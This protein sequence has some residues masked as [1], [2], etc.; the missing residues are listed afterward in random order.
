MPVDWLLE[1]SKWPTPLR[2]VYAV[3]L[4]VSGPIWFVV[5]FVVLMLTL[6]VSSLLVMLGAMGILMYELWMGEQP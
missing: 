1:P 5:W 4:P 6:F 3:T 2:R